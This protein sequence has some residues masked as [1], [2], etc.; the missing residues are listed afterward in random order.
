MTAMIISL[1]GYHR[2]A[3]RELGRGGVLK[4]G[5]NGVAGRNGGKEFGIN[6]MTDGQRQRAYSKPHVFQAGNFGNICLVI[7]LTHCATRR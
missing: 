4:R 2:G 5:R 3:C 7:Q 6:M 1:H